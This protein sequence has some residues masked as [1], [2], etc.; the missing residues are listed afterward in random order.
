MNLSNLMFGIGHLFCA[1]MLAAIGAVCAQGTMKRNS[2]VGVR[3]KKALESDENWKKMNEYGGKRLMFWSAILAVI[4][5]ASFFVPLGTEEDPNLTL[6]LIL[7]SA[8]GFIVIPLV[9][10]LHIFGKKL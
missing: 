3:T 4:A 2:L 10:E 6:I 7:A 8:P 9:V 1:G 5:V